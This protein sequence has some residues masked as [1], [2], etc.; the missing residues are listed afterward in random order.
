L[1][2]ANRK[3]VGKEASLIDAF[4][5][6]SGWEMKETDTGIRYQIYHEGGGDS[7][8]TGQVVSVIY[9]CYLL[10]GTRI[11]SARADAPKEFRVGES[12]VVSGLHEAVTLLSEG[13]S[14][15]F[16]IP[17]YQAYGLTGERNIPPNAALFYDLY[18]QKVD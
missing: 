10:D 14:I 9:T 6:N 12:N 16:I 7:V 17:S 1:I 3:K 2:E 4:V 8:K 5:E 11:D 13:D 15:R 18:L